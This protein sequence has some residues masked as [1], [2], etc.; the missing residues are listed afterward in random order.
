MEDNKEYYFQTTSDMLNGILLKYSS[1][2]KPN[3][4]IIENEEINES[5]LSKYIKSMEEKIPIAKYYNAD[6]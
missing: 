4:Q 1:L 6:T 3:E 5:N 2:E